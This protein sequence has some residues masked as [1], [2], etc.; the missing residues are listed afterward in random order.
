MGRTVVVLSGSVA[1]GKSTL[2]RGLRDRYGAR[3]LRTQDL[4][5]ARGAAEGL[6][7]LTDRRALQHYGEELDERTGGRWVADDLGPIV[8]ALPD[9]SVVVVDAIRRGEQLDALHEAFGR[10]VSHVHLTAGLSTLAERY[11]DRKDSGIVELGDYGLVRADPTESQVP[12]LAAHADLKID[13]DATGQA[14]VLLRCAARLGLLPAIGE[15]L[16][17]VVVGA[18]YGSEGKGNVC[19]YLAPEYD[20]LVRVGGPNAGH[21]VPTD[22]PYTHRLLPSGTLSNTAATLV[23]GAGA[24]LD[25][26]VLL[27]EISE[28][29]VDVD[30]LH[31]DPHAM[32]IEV[33]DIAAE[34]ELSSIGSTRRGVGHATAR[35]ING[36]G[37][38]LAGGGVRLAKDVPEL[39]PYTTATAREVLDD[40]Y[41]AGRRALLEGTQGTHLSLY[42]GSY[43]HVTSRDTTTAGCLAEAGISPRRVRRVVVVARTYPIRVGGPS[44]PMADELSVQDVARAAGLPAHEIADR[45]IGSVSG[46]PR[47]IAGFDWEALRTAA[48]INGATD[49]ALTFAD[50]FDSANQ[51]VHRFD[52]LT[53]ETIAFIDGVEQVAGCRVS[54]VSTD[55]AR[56]AI[57]DRRDWRGHVLDPPPDE[58]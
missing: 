46:V 31:I 24:V 5:R 15:P 4:L 36:R 47:R 58:P 28:C 54:L 56:R 16:V 50:Y 38:Y 41:R 43:P 7:G 8:S 34:Q 29:R 27:A 55:F 57:L 39:R 11:A 14:G 30:R 40:S 17:D 48:E 35:R 23:L 3:H 9:R 42:H 12:A 10:R 37:S 2:A 44:G 6:G 22:P 26:D 49:I 13:T 21:K 45:E 20:V 51:G 53:P 19:F 18:Q 1:S 52:Q 33:E 32:I 25:V